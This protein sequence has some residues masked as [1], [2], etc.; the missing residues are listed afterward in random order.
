[1]TKRSR[2]RRFRFRPEII[3]LAVMLNVR[4][5]LSLR[6]AQDLPD[7]RGIDKSLETARS[8]WQRFGPMFAAEIRK[9]RI[10]GMRSS[11]WRWHLG[12][13][14]VGINGEMPCLGRAVAHR[15]EARER[16]VAKTRENKTA[17][18]FVTAASAWHGINSSLTALDE[19]G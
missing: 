9:R 10:A 14:F 7:E 17:L 2:F 1:M 6:N 8:W 4:L 16:Y 19:T 15:G 5:P 11:R 3:R 12:E 13:M 18:K